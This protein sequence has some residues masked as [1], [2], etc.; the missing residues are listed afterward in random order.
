MDSTLPPEQLKVVRG[1]LDR[2]CQDGIRYHKLR[3]RQAGAQ[4]FVSVHVLVPGSWT[5]QRGHALA[6]RVEQEIHRALP[7]TTVDTHLESWAD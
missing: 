4:Q 6:E 2:V 7:N 3:T 5:V 1:I